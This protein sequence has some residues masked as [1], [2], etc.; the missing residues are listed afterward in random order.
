MNPKRITIIPF[1]HGKLTQDGKTSEPD[2]YWIVEKWLDRHPEIKARM[3]DIRVSRGR[4]TLPHGGKTELIRATII[5]GE[6]I[7][8]YDPAVDLD[9]Y[10]YFLS[11]DQG[12]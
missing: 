8:G 11:D 5:A 9:L 12:G 3:Q 1:L 6:D 4:M 2:I 7:E 10:E